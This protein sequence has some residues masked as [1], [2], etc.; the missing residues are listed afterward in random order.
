MHDYRERLR[1]EGTV[2]AACGAV[3]AV[4]VLLAAPGATDGPASTIV[5][6][7]V[8]AL[9]MVTLGR[10]SVRRA[11]GGAAP[12]PDP[13]GDGEPTAPWKVVAVVAVL[14]LGFGLGTGWDAGL[15]VGGGCVIVGLAQAL[16]FSRIV[17]REEERTGRRFHRTPGSS[18]L[19]GT[20]LGAR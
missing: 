14:T 15:R 13:A 8:V 16:L 1:L 6:L 18:I 9:L 4:A 5:Q 3:A 19:T 17:A 10:R 2:L 7:V 20:R 12:D 11:L